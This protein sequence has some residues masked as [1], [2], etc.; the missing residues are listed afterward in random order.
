LCVAVFDLAEVGEGK[1]RY[2]DGCLWY[3]GVSTH[4]SGKLVSQE[5]QLYSEWSCSDHLRQKLS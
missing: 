2:G 4:C 1:V 5:Y 3:K